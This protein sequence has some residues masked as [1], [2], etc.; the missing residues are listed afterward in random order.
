MRRLWCAALAVV[1]LGIAHVDS[2]SLNSLSWRSIGPFRGGR[3]LAV[4]GVPGE[5][6]HF[7]FGAVDGG[8]W[9]SKNAGRTW[10]PI[11]DSVS[12][13][14]VGAIAV[15]PS[16][17]KTLYVGTGEADMR[18]DIAYGHG[19]YK[20]VDGGATWTHIGLEDTRQIG[21]VL[22]DPRNANVVYVAA[23]GHQYAPNAARGV[24]K[25][26]DGGASWQKVL[27]K[28]DDTGA[29][30]LSMD[31]QDPDTVYASLWQ[32]RRPP[33]NTYPPSNGPGSGLYKT[34]DGGATWKQL[35]NGLPAKVGHIGIAVSP[36]NGSRVYAQ[37][38]TGSDI[39][40]GGVY[41]SD[42]GGAT[43]AHLAGG[44]TQVRIWQRGWYFGGITADP[45]NADVVYVM[46][47]A[48]YRSSDGGKTFDAIKGSP[49]GDDYHTL[50]IYPDDS[51]RMILGTDQGT[52]VSL[53]YAKTWSSWLN[54]PTAQFYHVATDDRF[55]YWVYGAQQ[56]SGAMAVRS[57]S[58]HTN[59]TDED[60]R[61]IN[62]GGENGYIAANPLRPGKI[63]GG[64]DTVTYEDFDTGSDQVIDPTLKYPE[65]VWRHTW[66]LPLVVSPVDKHALY[67]SRQQIF[68]SRDEGRTWSIVSPDLTR[69]GDENH[70]A[71]LD[72]ATIADSGGL[73]RRGVVYAIAPSPLTANLIWAGTDDGYVWMT[74]DGGAHWT[75]VTPKHVTPWSKVG[76]I[77]ASHFEGGRAYVAIDRHRLDDYTPYIYRTTDS[78]KTWAL[79]ATGIP[80]GAFV[81]AVRE[82]TRVPGLLYAAT[83]RGMYVSFD[84]AAH[85]Q[86]LQQNLPMT[87]VRDIDV[88]RDDL[89][90][91]THGRGFWIMDDMTP[92]RQMQHASANAYLFA[93]QT[94]YRIRR[95]GGG[96]FNNLSDEGTPIQLDEPQA[97]NSPAGLIIDYMLHAAPSTAV[98]IDIADGSGHIVRSYSSADRPQSTNPSTVD[99]APWWITHDPV[100]SAE[101]GAHRFVWDFHA[102]SPD[103]PIMPPGNY[104]IRLRVNGQTYTQ[105]A[106]LLR[107]P[108]IPATDADLRAQYAF[109]NAIEAKLAQI[110]AA[111]MRA[112]KLN[113]T[114]A[115]RETLVAASRS[116]DPD[117]SVGKPAQDFISLNY[118]ANAYG[119]LEGA[120]ESDDSAPTPDMRAALT[121]LDA[122]LASTLAKLHSIG[123]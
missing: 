14:S 72:A 33:W 70:P 123:K 9:E 67:T 64:S 101:T 37:V 95:A 21:K 28:N 2:S 18:S 105:K 112:K 80:E 75:N 57:Q 114:L 26:T 38:D 74:H 51:N 122:T 27:F 29:I 88:H 84:D 81:N 56:D 91:A 85:W 30:D 55:P 11:F 106:T 32:T 47:T 78:G 12:D 23:L 93:P 108:R 66:T 97:P 90:I 89:V 120:V 50:W 1:C 79:T 69:S 119:N 111:R 13:G 59:L 42:D 20:S 39:A 86:S 99:I 44:K 17:T 104:T 15:A 48:T 73:P 100:P 113:L 4:T 5:P 31:I 83:E 107:D 24:F 115:Q 8:V 41:R 62:V 65:T 102:K 40:A 117:D 103:G 92:L 49:G 54:Q 116:G 22:V 71:N 96:G 76:T 53:D 109:A 94:T 46:N 25:T 6:E 34:I 19:M 35:T 16:N 7:Y 52:I 58:I 121:K 118:L 61:P 77:E 82:D 98:A 63:F 87:S 3:A 45:K 110:D 36:A 10:N 43:W 68:R 60:W